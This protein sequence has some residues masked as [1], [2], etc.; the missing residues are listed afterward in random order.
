MNRKKD[1]VNIV[2]NPIELCTIIN[3]EMNDYSDPRYKDLY[4]EIL[5]DY[6]WR[7]GKFSTIPYPKY[8]NRNQNEKQSTEISPE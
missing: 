7:Y 3:M 1:S 2:I 6:N 4:E 8:T 5:I